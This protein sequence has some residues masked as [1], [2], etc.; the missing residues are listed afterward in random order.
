MIDTIYVTNSV[1]RETYPSF[2][3]IFDAAPNYAEVIE[4]AFTNRSIN[5]NM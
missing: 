4:A 3:K 5:F 2:V 1:Y